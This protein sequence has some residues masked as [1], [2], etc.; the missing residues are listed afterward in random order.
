MDILLTEEEQMVRDAA[1]GFLE[2]ECSPA[3]AREMEQDELGYPPELWKQ[4]AD[5]GWTGMSLPEEYEI[6]RAHV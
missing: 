6:G 4:I 3:L 5:L 1:R 2:S